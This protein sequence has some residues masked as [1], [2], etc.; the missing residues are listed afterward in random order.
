MVVKESNRTPGSVESPEPDET[1]KLEDELEPEGSVTN[2][3]EAP[4]L[5]EQSSREA[6]EQ[7]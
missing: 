1:W 5:V 3:W 6:A 2:D 7:D 4:R